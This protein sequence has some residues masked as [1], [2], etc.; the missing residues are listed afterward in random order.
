MTSSATLTSFAYDPELSA[1]SLK[2]QLL[3]QILKTNVKQNAASLD[4]IKN[5]YRNLAI[6]Q[7]QGRERGGT[8][9]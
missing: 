1:Q 2:R 4:D 9:Q 7:V 5:A 8:E 3:A 6:A